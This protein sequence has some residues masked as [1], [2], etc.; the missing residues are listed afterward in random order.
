VDFQR[1]GLREKMLMSSKGPWILIGDPNQDRSSWLER[2]LRDKFVVQDVSRYTYF[3]DLDTGLVETYGRIVLLSDDLLYDKDAK[4]PILEGNLLL[5]SRNRCARLGVIVAAGHYPNL[6]GVRK[7]LPGLFWV[8]MPRWETPRPGCSFVPT[9]AEESKVVYELVGGL[10]DHLPMR[11]QNVYVE[12]DRDP[13]LREQVRSLS[14]SRDLKEGEELIGKMVRDFFQ[15]CEAV[16][17]GKLVQGKSGAK[18][19]RIFPGIRDPVSGKIDHRGFDSEHVLKLTRESWK[20]LLEGQGHDGARDTLAKKYISHIAERKSPPEELYDEADKATRYAVAENRWYGLCYDFL[21]EA[22]SSPARSK[23]KTLGKFIDLQSALV[24]DPTTFS[25]RTK[26][27]RFDPELVTAEHGSGEKDATANRVS[28]ERER[29]FRAQLNW[30]CKIWYKGPDAKRQ[31]RSLWDFADREKEGYPQAPPYRLSGITKGYILRFLDDPDFT[32]IGHSLFGDD[33]MTHTERVLRFVEM[34]DAKSHALRLEYSVVVSPSHGDL[35][36][37]NILLWLE[38]EEHPFL[39]DLATYSREGHALQDFAKLETEIKF[40]V[41]DRQQGLRCDQSWAYDL[42][43]SQLPL[44]IKVEDYLLGNWKANED[45]GSDGYQEHVKFCLHLTRLIR[46]HAEEVQGQEI[47]PPPTLSFDE[48]YRVPLLHH[49]LRAISYDTL[50]TF[51]RLL[52]VYSAS[53]LIKRCNDIKH[54]D[55]QRS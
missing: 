54:P 53:H 45:L 21:G 30:L 2:L 10:G 7:Q 26:D 29:I 28:K 33:W 12:L 8:D 9:E 13:S 17:V 43:H 36:A 11:R 5:L 23:G 51:K 4:I 50:S 14:K 35:N 15:D 40:S 27:T 47:D 41:M 31:I 16:W 25:D 18:V 20:V 19:F 1:W 37:S 52:A 38:Q 42:T 39:I 34:P 49:T 46:E 22:D 48:E 6:G 32:M 3:E 24:S 55:P 44:W